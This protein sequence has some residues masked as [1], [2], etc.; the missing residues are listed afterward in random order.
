MSRWKHWE[1]MNCG[2]MEDIDVDEDERNLW[3][4]SQNAVMQ[5]VIDSFRRVLPQ[6]PP[7]GFRPIYI[8]YSNDGPVT[9]RPSDRGRYCIK[10]SAADGFYCQ[11][12]YQFSHELCHLYADP[13]VGN[14][15]IECICEMM[16]QH[17]LEDLSE[18]WAKDPPFPNWK[19]H[20][21][22]FKIYLDHHLKQ[23]HL[24]TIQAPRKDTEA[25]AAWLRADM[26]D[27][28]NPYNWVRN[29]VIAELIRP[30]FESHYKSWRI[31]PLLGKAS[32]P[33]PKTLLDGGFTE[34]SFDRLQEI[35]PKGTKAVVQRLRDIL[36]K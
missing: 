5:S 28:D 16:S 36:R 13:R 19:D 25:L 8:S 14:W 7:L 31:I 30:I 6:P 29:Q 35:A 4:R 18:I 23:A 33:Y 20:A 22:D 11:I 9:R 15:F 24:K 2:L 32:I 26:S 34:F 10:L 17:C 3:C 1:I 12:A 27:L 21:V